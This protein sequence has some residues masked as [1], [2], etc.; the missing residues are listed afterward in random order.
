M[1][2]ASGTLSDAIAAR[3]IPAELAPIPIDRSDA[4][5]ATAPIGPSFSAFEEHYPP[6]ALR[7]ARGDTLAL[8]YFLSARP[9]TN[10]YSFASDLGHFVAVTA[11]QLQ[12]NAFLPRLAM[13][14][15]PVFCELR[16]TRTE[17]AE[18]SRLVKMRENRR[19]VAVDSGM[20]SLFES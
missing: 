6:G 8:T 5:E 16:Q 12:F 19:Y 4:V 11:R 20:P 10:A 17:E 1:G 9:E 3:T 15:E 7:N 2:N 13:F 14:F 18:R